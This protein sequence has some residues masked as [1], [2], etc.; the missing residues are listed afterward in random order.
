MKKT[1]SSILGVERGRL[2]IKAKT[3]EG[4]GLIGKKKAVASWAL[5]LLK[6]QSKPGEQTA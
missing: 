1:L 4:I 5:V 6:M 2:S 3:N